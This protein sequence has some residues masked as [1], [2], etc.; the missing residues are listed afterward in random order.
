MGDEIDVELSVVMLMAV[1][2]L[3][4]GLWGQYGFAW[5]KVMIDVG[6]WLWVRV[7]LGVLVCGMAGWVVLGCKDVMKYWFSKNF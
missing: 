5:D 7:V 6:D 1:G 3:A 4:Y 2:V